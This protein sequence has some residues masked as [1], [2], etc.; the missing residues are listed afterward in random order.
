MIKLR[1]QLEL[2]NR[3]ELSVSGLPLVSIGSGFGVLN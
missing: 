3:A 2:R 1:G